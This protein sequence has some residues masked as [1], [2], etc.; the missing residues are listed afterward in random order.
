MENLGFVMEAEMEILKRLENGVY[1]RM[2]DE[3]VLDVC[4]G[5]YA[6]EVGGLRVPFDWEAHESGWNQDGTFGV[7][8]GTGWMFK[9]FE[10]DH[11][12]DEAY[13]EIGLDRDKITA[14]FLAG[15]EHIDDF[16]INFVD[17]DGKE[18]E[19]GGWKANGDVESPFKLK[20]NRVLFQ[21]VNLEKA[22]LVRQEVLDCFNKGVRFRELENVLENALK[23]SEAAPELSIDK[24]GYGAKGL[25]D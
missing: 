10:L 16:Y 18:C 3:D 15:A 7:N 19:V 9:N 2:T 21:D 4:V 8:T 20:L 14:E 24:G 13:G 23:R 6:F 12:N 25:G 22:F 11:C 5:G 17:K 1:V